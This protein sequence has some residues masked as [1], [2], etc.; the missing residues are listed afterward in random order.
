[1][2]QVPT[3]EHLKL[4]RAVLDREMARQESRAVVSAAQAACAA[5]H[6]RLV[7]LVTSSGSQAFVTRSL[8]LAKEQY[9]FLEGLRGGASAETCLDGA[10][11]ALRGAD[12]DEGYEALVLVLAHMVCLLAAFI[13]DDLATRIVAEAW[14]GVPLGP[15]GAQ[16][17][18]A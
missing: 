15:T 10:D 14:P 16:E 4:A 3:E 5:F 2:A 9:P 7:P 6:R 13:G 1:M 12:P 11:G 18:E 17:E 8:H